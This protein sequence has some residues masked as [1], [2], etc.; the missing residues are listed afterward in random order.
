M[1]WKEKGQ[2][3]HGSN[4]R[5]K[6]KKQPHLASAFCFYC[7]VMDLLGTLHFL[8]YIVMALSIFFPVSIVFYLRLFFYV[9]VATLFPQ[10]SSSA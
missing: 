6:K 3:L 8:L 10:E 5:A 7:C 9:Y 4:T 1:S 2:L